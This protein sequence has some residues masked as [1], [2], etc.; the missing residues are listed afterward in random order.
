MSRTRATEDAMFWFR[1]A[2][3]EPW[4]VN[5]DALEMEASARMEGYCCYCCKAADPANS[6]R[7]QEGE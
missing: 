6:G 4:Q 7:K 2:G 5:T 1:E 3:Y